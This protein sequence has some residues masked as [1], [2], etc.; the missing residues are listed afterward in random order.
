MV[1]IWSFIAVYVAMAE[2]ATVRKGILLANWEV[3]LCQ[4]GKH[5]QLSPHDSLLLKESKSENRECHL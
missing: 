3:L 5:F 2:I 1:L 4:K